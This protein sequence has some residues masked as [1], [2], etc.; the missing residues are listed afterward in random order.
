LNIQTEH[1]ENH[2]ARLTVEVEQARVEKAMQ[3]AAKRV[4]AKANIP[5]FRKGKAPYNVIVRYFGAAALLEEAIEDLGDSV[6]QEAL[7]QSGIKPFAIGQL[8]N[9]E[10]E[11]AL[12]LVFTVPETPEIDLGNY[13]ELR[14]PFEPIEVQDEMVTRAIAQTL[15]GRALI[16][17][18]ERPAQMG[19]KVKMSVKGITIHDHS[20]HADHDHAETADDALAIDSGADDADSA[21]LDSTAST[22]LSAD[23]PVQSALAVQ[24]EVQ[25]DPFSD[26]IDVL[27]R[28]DAEDFMPGFSEHIVGVS[29]GEETTFTLTYPTDHP[30]KD[31]A[32]HTFNLTVKV[33][34]VQSAILPLLND[35]FAKAVTDNA[36]DNLL[37]YRIKVRKDLQEA[38]KRTA[39]SNYAALALSKLVENTTFKYPEVAVE[40]Y[41]DDILKD[42]D[43][44]FRER[45]LSLDEVMKIENRD[46]ATLRGMYRDT[47]EQRLRR[48]LA[49]A[50]VLDQEKINVT[51][52]ELDAHV[53]EMALQF[54]EQAAVFKQLLLTDQNR[55]NVLGD[56]LRDK[57]LERLTAIT[58]GEN[59]PLPAPDATSA[60]TEIAALTPT[61]E[62]AGGTASDEAAEAVSTESVNEVADIAANGDAAQPTDVTPD[63]A[64]S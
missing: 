2:T 1:L 63:T 50:K 21:V 54:G 43:Q 62:R 9:I 41:V 61:A 64:N 46:A 51:S 56:M 15:E 40:E 11:P 24:P 60:L 52:D 53:D 10:T 38:A 37:D 23:T 29:A 31:V 14:V 44:S 17:P 18:A 30:D 22:E 57:T 55:T 32:G 13:R 6:Y 26:E 25:G 47:A 42:L 33:E 59:P 12:K 49:L 27:L 36:I 5:G 3:A 8:D 34:Q 20:A 28:T 58:R 19:D 45:G 39:D 16:E 48:S 4:A 35:D 7:M